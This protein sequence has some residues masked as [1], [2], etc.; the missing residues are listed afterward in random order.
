MIGEKRVVIKKTRKAIY[1]RR[2]KA[3]E[4]MH[5]SIERLLEYKVAYAKKLLSDED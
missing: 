2:A 5:A 1:D 3:E 4:E